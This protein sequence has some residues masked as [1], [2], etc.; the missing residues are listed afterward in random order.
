MLDV[1]QAEAD[2][3]QAA[4]RW[5]VARG[6]AEIGLRLIAALWRFVEI[7][8]YLKLGR[9]GA[10][11]VLGI[12]G[13]SKFPALRS[14]VLSGAGI[15]AYRQGDFEPAEKMFEERL[16]IG[17]EQ[18]DYAA[19]ANALSD[20]G[21]IAKIRGEYQRALRLY[22]EG[23]EIERR[24]GNQRQIA[25]AL[26]NLGAVAA[27]TGD[28]DKATRV[29]RQS[30]TLFEGAGN[31]RESAFPLNHLARVAILRREF[32]DAWFYAQRSLTYR[33]QLS[34]RRGVAETLRS[35][36]WI[37]IETQDYVT[38]RD[39]LKDSVTSAMEVGDKQG[40]SESIDLWALLEHRLGKHGHVRFLVRS[41]RSSAADDRFCAARLGENHQ[42]WEPRQCP[43]GAWP[44]G[45]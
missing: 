2:N 25:V 4:V 41:S 36:S 45:L 29:L 42:G 21:K 22:T 37:Y 12:P 40:L 7:R 23:L 39:A 5:A 10:E 1:L 15:L 34:D 31:L 3:L 44:R 30:V 33:N 35:L 43:A 38:A 11:G 20:L 16:A 17:R 8:G 24:L 9:E 19:I 6:E 28:Y 13:A 18:G 26:N 27:A 14:K 32:H